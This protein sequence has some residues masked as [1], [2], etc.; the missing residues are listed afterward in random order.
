MTTELEKE[1]EKRAKEFQ[2]IVQK[3]ELYD[4]DAMLLAKHVIAKE[5]EARI[6]S[7]SYFLGY[8]NNVDKVVRRD[9]RDRTKELQAKLDEVRK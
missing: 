6:D 4:S 7:I 8:D 2:K 3:E 9:A 5:L 1:I